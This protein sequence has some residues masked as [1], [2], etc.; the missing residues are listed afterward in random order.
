MPKTLENTS[1][2][3]SSNRAIDYFDNMQI[4]PGNKTTHFGKIQKETGIEYEDMLF[5]DDESR[6]KNVE[7]LG[8]TMWLVR[9]G[10]TREEFDNGVK[11][12]RTRKGKTK[13][14]D[15]ST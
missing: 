5:F 7:V 14:E 6:N 8:V 10:V 12:W 15:G 11:S 13:D 9:D 3:G 4:Y 1:T 2:S